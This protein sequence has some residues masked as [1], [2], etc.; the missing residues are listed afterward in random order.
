MIGKPPGLYYSFGV[1]MFAV[2]AYG[3]VLLVTQAAERRSLGRDVEISHVAKGVAMAGMFVPAW[4]F[5]PNVLWELSSSFC[6]SGS[7]HVRSNPCEPGVCTCRI[8]LSMQ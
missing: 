7:Q 8:L 5:G 2:A 4:A 6:W 1:M 3:L